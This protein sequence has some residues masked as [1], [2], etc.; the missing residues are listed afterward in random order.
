MSTG[1]VIKPWSL[2]L[3]HGVKV[4]ESERVVS[5]SVSVV[6]RCHWSGRLLQNGRGLDPLPEQKTV[7]GEQRGRVRRQVWRRNILYLQV[8]PYG[9]IFRHKQHKYVTQDQQMSSTTT[10][11]FNDLLISSTFMYFLYLILL[12]PVILTKFLFILSVNDLRS[13]QESWQ[14]QQ[15]SGLSAPVELYWTSSSY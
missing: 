1:K 13:V 6:S 10:F 9:S 7:L 14:T 4:A 5:V 3:V 15:R 11:F 2:L 8:R 12:F